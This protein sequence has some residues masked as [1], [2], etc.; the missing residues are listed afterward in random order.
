ME[1]RDDVLA[2][3]EADERLVAIREEAARRMGADPDPGHD[4]EHALRVA[5]WTVRLGAS[6]GGVDRAEAIAAALLH[7]VVLSL[8]HI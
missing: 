5:L 8:I 1:T 4:L 2:A 3:I 6:E 7:D